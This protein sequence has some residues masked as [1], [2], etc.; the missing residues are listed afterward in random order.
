[1]LLGKTAQAINNTN[2]P[3]YAPSAAE[4]ALARVAG[5]NVWLESGSDYIQTDGA[6]AFTAWVDRISGRRFIPSTSNAPGLVTRAARRVPQLNW[7]GGTP[8]PLWA[9]DR[10][11]LLSAAGYTIAML[12]RIPQRV[13][14]GGTEISAAV[15]PQGAIVGANIDTDYLMMAINNVGVFTGRHR[16]SSS[17]IVGEVA[18]V[19]LMWDATWHLHVVSYDFA[20]KTACYRRDG[21][22]EQVATGITSEV[23]VPSAD[24]ANPTY[25]ALQMVLGGGGALGTANAARAFEYGGVWHV[26]GRALHLAGAAAELAA[27]EAYGAWVKAQLES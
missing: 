5:L 8:Q 16:A 4:N 3:I 11:N 18:P 7:A 27:M 24:P 12:V 14:D 21:M 20:T 22:T 10:A 13:A 9:E 17:G 15:T 23:V 1:M 26:S 2:L 19:S 25:R 6:G